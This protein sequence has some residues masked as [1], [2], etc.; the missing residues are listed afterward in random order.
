MTPADVAR[1]LASA[2]AFDRRTVGEFDVAA[3]HKVIGHLPLA[4]AI[5][6]VARHYGN[7]RQ[8]IMPSDVIQ[9]ALALRN[10]RASKN[11]HPVREL[12]SRF[13]QD[14]DRDVRI[15]DGI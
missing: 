9:N 11:P 7:T 5:E 10:E 14:Q 1:V 6:A 4:D 12:P 13:E 3:W 8:W 2:A 15:V